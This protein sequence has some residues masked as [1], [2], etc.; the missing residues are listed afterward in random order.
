MKLRDL[1]ERALEII[2]IAC[3]IVFIVG[4]VAI[5]MTE[6]FRSLD[7]FLFLGVLIISSVSAF[8]ILLIMDR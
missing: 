2:A 7:S 8:G 5:G 4:S 3:C 1:I 6:E